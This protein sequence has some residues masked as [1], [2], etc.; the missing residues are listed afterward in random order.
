MFSFIEDSQIYNT[1]PKFQTKEKQ[2]II[3]DSPDC[4]SF[5]EDSDNK[6]I[7]EVEDFHKDDLEQYQQKDFDFQSKI[8]QDVD[9]KIKGI[10]NILGKLG[11]SLDRL[12]GEVDS[13]IHPDHLTKKIFNAQLRSNIFQENNQ[14]YDNEN[15]ESHITTTVVH[16]VPLNILFAQKQ[17]ERSCT[18][19][20]SKIK[21]QIKKYKNN[22]QFQSYK[23][24]LKEIKFNESNKKI[25]DENQLS[26]KGQQNINARRKLDFDF[27]QDEQFSEVESPKSL[28]E[29]GFQKIQNNFQNQF[30]EKEEQNDNQNPRKIFVK[31]IQKE[32][33]FV[34]Y[35]FIYRTHH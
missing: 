14:I 6:F 11:T 32:N 30:N 4:V 1:P 31:D 33:D 19:S 29:T 25:S 2:K 23:T 17:I 12:R 13:M 8:Q 10:R 7:F 24:L 34:N 9:D 18:K 5:C 27:L 22:Q 28:D 21:S 3:K 15:Q 16:T 20:C 35:Y 26:T